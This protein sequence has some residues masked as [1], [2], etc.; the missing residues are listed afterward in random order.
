MNNMKRGI[1]KMHAFRLEN[2]VYVYNPGN[3]LSLHSALKDTFR[4]RN[5]EE[6]RTRTLVAYLYSLQ[7]QLY[8]TGHVSVCVAIDNRSWY[9]IETSD[10]D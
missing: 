7:L 6:K 4:K 1:K 8:P 9:R 5:S 2:V 10:R 3:M